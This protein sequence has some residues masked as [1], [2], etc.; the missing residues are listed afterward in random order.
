MSYNCSVLCYVG[1]TQ[2]KMLK[3]RPRLEDQES[4]HP[5]VESF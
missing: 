5:H 3:G 4:L 1:V 2:K